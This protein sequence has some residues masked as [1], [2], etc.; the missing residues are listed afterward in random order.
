MSSNICIDTAQRTRIPTPRPWTGSPANAA[1]TQTPANQNNN[2][3]NL[4]HHNT[5]IPTSQWLQYISPW[6]HRHDTVEPSSMD[7]FPPLLLTAHQRTNHTSK[8][9]VT[10]SPTTAWCS[11]H[12]RHMGPAPT[13]G[14]GNTNQQCSNLPENKFLIWN[15]QP[16]QNDTATP[17]THPVKTQRDILPQP[18]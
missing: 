18:A 13:H 2:R 3:N 15:H 10:T 16:Q 8:T 12:G 9:M 4:R 17:C 5:A 11:N 7:G 6:T 1:A 14:T